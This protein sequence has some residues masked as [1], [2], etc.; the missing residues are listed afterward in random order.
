MSAPGFP[1]HTDRDGCETNKAVGLPTSSLLSFEN[2]TTRRPARLMWAKP[3]SSRPFRSKGNAPP[4]PIRLCLETKGH[5]LHPGQ[6]SNLNIGHPVATAPPSSSCRHKT[7][8][9][10]RASRTRHPATMTALDKTE[11]RRRDGQRG[12][13]RHVDSDDLRTPRQVPDLIAR[14]SGVMRHRTR[15][16]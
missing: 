12:K 1:G 15:A 7:P 14:P 4:L 5:M 11:G 16:K 10:P 3:W 6:C 2:Q 9:E 8:N 13:H